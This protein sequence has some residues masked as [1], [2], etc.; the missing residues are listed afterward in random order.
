M[1][2]SLWVGESKHDVYENVNSAFHSGRKKDASMG[3]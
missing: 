2:F 1:S 3:V